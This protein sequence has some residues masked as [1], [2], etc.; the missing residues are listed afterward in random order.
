[1]ELDHALVNASHG[2]SLA[3][4]WEL[5]RNRLGTGNDGAREEEATD[6]VS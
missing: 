5:L 6:V 1:M 3:E 4:L 2:A